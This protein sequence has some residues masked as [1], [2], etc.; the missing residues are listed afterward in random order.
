V[1][2]GGHQRWENNPYEGDDPGPGA[3][4]RS[5]IAALDPE[6]GV[7]F[8][9]NPG[10]SRG[11]GAFAL[12]PT[13]AGLWVGSDT[14]RL[15]GEYHARIGFFPLA[16]GSVVPADQP[17]T[18]PGSMYAVEANGTLVKRS[19]D[20]TTAGPRTVVASSGFSDVRGAFMLGNRLFAGTASGGITVRTFAGGSFGSPSAVDLYG[21]TPIEWRI[22]DMTGMFYTAGRV[23]YTVAGS[24]TLWFRYFSQQSSIFGACPTAYPSSTATFCVE[25]FDISGTVWA[26]AQGVTLAGGNLF[27]VDGAGQ[28]W[29][30][31]WNGGS[32]GTASPVAGQN[33]G[34]VRA[35]FVGP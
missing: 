20:G 1:Y 35:L 31:P 14:V 33:W 2:T 16:G 22:T 23:Y 32:P 29:T 17:R 12:V 8:S 26:A 28:V 4:P 18:L 21:L 24:S 27:W 15:A 3:V 11:V 7:P 9:W 10:R 5:G 19:F 30:A 25:D 13:A 6:N 34:P